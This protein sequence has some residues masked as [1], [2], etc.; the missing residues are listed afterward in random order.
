VKRTWHEPRSRIPPLG[1]PLTRLATLP[2]S[3]GGIRG[4]GALTSFLREHGSDAVAVADPGYLF[5]KDNPLYAKSEA[6][7]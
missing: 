4:C 1:S 2:P 3:G 7:L 6:G 5:S